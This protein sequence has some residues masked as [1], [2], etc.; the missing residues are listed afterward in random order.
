M[1]SSTKSNQRG[2]MDWTGP[3]RI[4]TDADPKDIRRRLAE[5]QPWRP[6]IEFSNGVSTDQFEQEH[7]FS[8]TPLWTLGQFGSVI[9]FADLHEVLDVGCNAGYNAIVLSRD[10]GARCLGFDVQQR[11]VDASAY[12]AELVGAD[13]EFRLDHAER[14]QRPDGFDLVLHSGTLYHLPNPLN[15]LRAAWENLRVGGWLALETQTYD[16]PSD[17]RLCYWLHG[18]N[19]DRS[20]FFAL[21]TRAVTEVLAL[22]GFDAVTEVGRTETRAGDREHMYRVMLAARK[23][24]GGDPLQRRWPPWA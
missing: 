16:H 21:S 10:F 15:G 8:R 24:E 7:P 4:H 6:L 11:H 2:D 14:V 1:T 17:E 12:L 23:S 5:W 3:L 13:C 9:P 22:L 18:L 20:N 19:N